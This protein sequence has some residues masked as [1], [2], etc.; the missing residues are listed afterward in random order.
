MRSIF[1]LIST[2]IKKLINS[3]FKKPK[4]DD[5]VADETTTIED[6]PIFETIEERT[7]IVCYYGCPNSNKAKKLQLSKKIYR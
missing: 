4:T 5:P 2:W 1:A 7:D 3:I 6:Y